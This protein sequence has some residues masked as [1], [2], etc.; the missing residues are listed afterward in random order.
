MFSSQLSCCLSAEPSKSI[1]CGLLR[2]SHSRTPNRHS[3]L[4]AYTGGLYLLPRPMFVRL[5]R[6][7]YQTL[8]RCPGAYTVKWT[9]SLKIE[10]KKWACLFWLLKILLFYVFTK[11]ILLYIIIVLKQYRSEKDM[12]YYSKINY[13]NQYMIS[14]SD[15]MDSLRNYIV[16]CEET[17]ER[18]WSENKRKVI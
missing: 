3:R 14:K 17:Q 1:S 7:A 15:V 6:R 8:R 10:R 4:G 13:M 12:D 16:H 2:A 9:V 11:C 5:D 18:G